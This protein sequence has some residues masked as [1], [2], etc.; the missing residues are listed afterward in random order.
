[1]SAF[2]IQKAIDHFDTEQMK[3]WCS[4]LYN[5]SGIFKYIYPFLN[6]MPVGADGAKQTYP[7]IYGLKGSLKAHRNYFIQ[8][9]YDLKQVE[10][11][12]VSTLGAQFY[13]S[14]ASLDK[15]YKLK[16]M[17]YRLTIPYRVQLST[18]NGVQADSGVVDAD[19]LHSLQLTRAFGENDPLKIIGAAKIKEL[20]WHED[21]FAIG[22][23]FGLLTSLVKLDMSVEKASGYRNGS[24]MASTNGMLLLEEVNMRNNRLARNGDNGNV[25]TLDL[26]WQGRLKKL[27]VRGTGLTR[28]KLATGAPVVQLCLPDTIEE[29]FLEYLTK[30]SD[31]GLILEGINNV[32]GYRY[33]NCPGID[34]FAMLER[35]HQARLNGSGK[36]ERFV[37][38]PSLSQGIKYQVSEFNGLYKYTFRLWV[39]T[40]PIKI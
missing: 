3:K 4:R 9:R 39:S 1:M 8:R 16:P 40:F 30:L 26:S 7:Q 2:S 35:L 31:S 32:R 21:A 38:L 29:L 20:V 33:T 22:F 11:G 18:S 17:Q 27:D 15:A 36:L 13:Q 19:V 12:Y 10:Y 6:E 5:K 25:A 34:G 24:F 28:V 23:N 37:R 14:T